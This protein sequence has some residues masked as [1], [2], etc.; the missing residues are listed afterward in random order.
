[1]HAWLDITVEKVHD[2]LADPVKKLLYLLLLFPR[3]SSSF[4]SFFKNMR[5]LL[6]TVS[7]EKFFEVS[8]EFDR[9]FS[10]YVKK[11]PSSSV[12]IATFFKM[13]LVDM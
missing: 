7:R 5:I 1:M 3:R 10:K 12:C 2:K 6:R 9:P 13:V 8:H 4:S 11:P